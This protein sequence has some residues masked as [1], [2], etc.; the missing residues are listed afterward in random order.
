MRCTLWPEGARGLRFLSHPAGMCECCARF[1]MLCSATNHRTGFR[2][3][4]TAYA[5]KALVYLVRPVGSDHA[6]TPC[7]FALRDTARSINPVSLASKTC[8]TQ[9]SPLPAQVPRDH[10]PRGYAHDNGACPRP[11]TALRN[12]AEVPIA[13]EKNFSPRMKFARLVNGEEKVVLGS[14]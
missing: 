12:S 4:S 13:G 5:T 10:V 2:G 7:C 11:L 1:D 9:V 3:P 6:P 8:V 14:T